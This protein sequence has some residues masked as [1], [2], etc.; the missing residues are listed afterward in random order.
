M[1]INLLLYLLI[2]IGG[3]VTGSIFQTKVLAPKIV[4]PSCPACPPS[5]EVSLQN[6]DVTKLKNK[7]T[8]TYAPQLNNV[9]I[10]IETKDSSL[11][12]QMLKVG[13]K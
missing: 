5:T 12:K 9:V 10:K 11:L 4:I 1:K 2:F 6:F 13:L 8:F 7:G 3:A